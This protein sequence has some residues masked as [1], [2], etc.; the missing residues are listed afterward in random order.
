MARARD[1]AANGL[2]IVAAAGR[3]CHN[4]S[5]HTATAPRR[6]TAKPMRTERIP[7]QF[8]L[9][10]SM[11]YRFS[12]RDAAGQS[13]SG[14]NLHRRLLQLMLAAAVAAG[15]LSIA[16]VGQEQPPHP[17]GLL[18]RMPWT[19][20]AVVGTPEPPAPFQA[21]PAFPKL[22]FQQPVF[23]AEE[24]GSNRLVVAE[25]SGKIYAFDPANA[26]TDARQ[27]FLD[28]KRELYSFSFHP[29]YEQNGQIFVF[30]PRDPKQ[31]GDQKSRVSRFTASLQAPRQCSQLLRQPT[32]LNKRR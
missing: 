23:V 29:R 15:P 6:T 32:D 11:I 7:R 21:V 26:S 31:S 5:L 4:G 1:P 24:P 30:S 17:A 20:S 10:R 8:P 27:L 3:P 13:V 22:K 9:R 12:L 18:A 25:L 14:Q 16:T 19:T 28:T 2:P